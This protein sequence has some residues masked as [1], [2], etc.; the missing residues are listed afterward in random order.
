[1]FRTRDFILLFT[2]IAFLVS[3]IGVTV[4]TQ[5][6]R[7]HSVAASS[8]ELEQQLASVAVREYSATISTREELTRSQRV[9]QMREKIAQSAELRAPDPVPEMVP[10][11]E[12]LATTTPAEELAVATEL[13]QCPSFAPYLGFWDARGLSVIDAEGAILV[14]RQAQSLNGSSTQVTVLQLPKR[15]APAP[16]QSCI[17]T[18][19]IGI[20]N[21]GS[22]IRNDELALYSVFSSDTRIGYALDGFPIYGTG[23]QVVDECGGRIQNGQYRYELQPDREAVINCFS[24]APVSLP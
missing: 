15:L 20:A 22:L 10:E 23:S 11:D 8:D 24:A 14:V 5:D 2:A 9:E 19:V 6:S 1:M 18:D 17:N 3:A 4:F 13:D 21:D 7:V 16:G 12:L